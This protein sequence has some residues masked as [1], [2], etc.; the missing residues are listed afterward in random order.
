VE[1]A[2]GTFVG[3]VGPSGAGK[4]TLLRA[5]AGLTP[6]AGGR[7]IFD[8]EDVTTTRPEDR[9]V[10]MVFQRPALLPN[11]NVARNVAF[12][13]EIRREHVDEI[14]RRVGA[15][16]RALHLEH[17]L[18]RR[19]SELSRGEEHLVQI[20][21]AMVRVP[22][23]LLLDEP[24]TNLDGPVHDRTRQEIGMLQE[25]YGVTTLMT[26]NDPRDTMS[27]PAMLAVIDGG[28]LVQYAPPMT[29]RDSPETLGAGVA[30]GE[31]SLVRAQVRAAVEGV[32]LVAAGADGAELRWPARSPAYADRV[33]DE[34][35]V[36]TRAEHVVRRPDGDARAVL[37]RRVAGSPPMLACRI[38]PDTIVAHGDA[39]ADEIGSLVRLHVDRATVFDATTHHAIT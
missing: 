1:I 39:D 6:V 10:G 18:L 31:M 37:Q 2:D 25:G 22:R 13:L 33:G 30:T 19:P 7:I 11:R 23:V 21:R 36:A 27:L 15:E 5:I 9:D 34:V 29:V 3:V 26:T 16:T 20:A 38:G 24:F 4:T 14:R 17:L 8:D 32:D 28:H 12:P 35:L